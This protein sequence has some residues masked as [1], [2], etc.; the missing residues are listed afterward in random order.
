MKPYYEKD[1]QTIYNMDCREFQIPI[2]SIIVTDPPFN[3]GYHYNE[4][5]DS[6]DEVDYYDMLNDL[7]SERDCVVIHYPEQLHRL[8]IRMERV[9]E[10]VVSWVYP[11][12][13]PR[14]HR[15]IAFYGV[16]PDFS[17][18]GQP[19]KNTTDKRIQQRIKDGKE[20][21]LY[22][23]WELNQVKNVGHE[24]TEHPCQMPLEVMKNVLGILPEDRTIVDPFLGSGTTLVASKYLN[25]KAVG[26]EISEKY[27]EIAAK[28]LDQSMLF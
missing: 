21:K 17:K 8:S 24:K 23:W 11:S 28:R 25:R 22:D 7:L 14:Q 6:M 3:V 5:K 16:K 13:T 2:D 18:V 15:D 9:P 10:R 1:G 4:Y 27:C 26:V 19:Y 20:A 12:N